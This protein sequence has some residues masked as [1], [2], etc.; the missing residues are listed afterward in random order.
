MIL[1]KLRRFVFCIIHDRPASGQLPT[2]TT[3]TS[4][5]PYDFLKTQRVCDFYDL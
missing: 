2:Q 5:D 3:P 4:Q 1:K